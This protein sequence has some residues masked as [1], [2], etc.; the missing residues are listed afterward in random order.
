MTEEEQKYFSKGTS[1]DNG[2]TSLEFRFHDDSSFGEAFINLGFR[3]HWKEEGGEVIELHYPGST[4]MRIEGYNLRELFVY[5]LDNNVKWVRESKRG[6]EDQLSESP[7]EGEV[8]IG[9]IFKYELI[10]PVLDS[11]TLQGRQQ[12]FYGAR[13]GQ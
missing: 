4:L 12:A 11:M 6:P 5:L 1:K 8:Y 10:D 3:H 2:E 9:R 7:E 13:E